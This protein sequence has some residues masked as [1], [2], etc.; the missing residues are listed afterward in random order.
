MTALKE[1]PTVGGGAGTD[2]EETR[3]P[4]LLGEAPSKAG[5]RFYMFPLSGNPAVRICRLMGWEVKGA[6]YWTLIDHFETLNAIERHADAY[7]WST[8]RSKAR[9][10]EWLRAERLK[11]DETLVVV[12]LGRKAAAA[13][14]LHDVHP[15]GSWTKMGRVQVTVCPHTSGRSRLWNEP[16]TAQL[17]KKILTEAAEF[18]AAS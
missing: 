11:P 18:A 17:V 13:V 4:L 5:D 14:G 16:S 8:A 15:F 10:R 12:C 3:R 9:W 2:D 1:R 7:P 6:A